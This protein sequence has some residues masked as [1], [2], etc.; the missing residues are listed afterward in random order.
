[1]LNC[2]SEIPKSDLIGSTN[3]E[4]ICRLISKKNHSAHDQTDDGPASNSGIVCQWFS[5]LRLN[6]KT[7]R[8]CPRNVYQPLIRGQVSHC[9]SMS[10]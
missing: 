7:L 4:M 9:S 8:V 6:L 10:A 1:M 2:V 5:C 3:S